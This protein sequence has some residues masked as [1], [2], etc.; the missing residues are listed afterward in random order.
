[1]MNEKYIGESLFSA[2]YKTKPTLQD[3]LLQEDTDRQFLAIK[4][5]VDNSN[6]PSW[7]IAFVVVVNALVCYQLSNRGE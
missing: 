7:Q 6:I 3:A 2:D 4:K 5:L 1:M